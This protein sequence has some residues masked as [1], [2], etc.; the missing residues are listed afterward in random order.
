MIPSRRFAAAV[1]AVQTVQ[2]VQAV[3]VR[4]QNLSF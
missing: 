1:Q 4:S 2:N 3:E